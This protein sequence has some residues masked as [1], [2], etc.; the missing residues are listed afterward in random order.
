VKWCV[1]F[2][3][4]PLLT[5]GFVVFWGGVRKSDL[6]FVLFPLDNADAVF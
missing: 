6:P 5:C 4:T 2:S 3:N 1:D